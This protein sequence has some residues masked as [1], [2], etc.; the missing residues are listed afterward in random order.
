M[1]RRHSCRGVVVRGREELR[2]GMARTTTWRS[3]PGALSRC[4]RL[5]VAKFVIGL[6][7]S[8]PRAKLTGLISD[9]VPLK[10]RPSSRRT[11]MSEAQLFVATPFTE[12]Y[13]RVGVGPLFRPFG[14]LSARHGISWPQ[15]RPAVA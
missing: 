12:I 13:E 6:A 11:D 10:R 14:G 4:T 7:V 8:D 15:N 2:V 9:R 5:A 3:H 1:T